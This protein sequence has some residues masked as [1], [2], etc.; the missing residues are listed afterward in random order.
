MERLSE[1]SEATM[2]LFIKNGIAVVAL[3]ILILAFALYV[4]LFRAPLLSE[5]FATAEK[6]SPSVANTA[7]TA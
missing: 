2:N 6:E 4:Y 5:Y 1:M 3:L 7:A